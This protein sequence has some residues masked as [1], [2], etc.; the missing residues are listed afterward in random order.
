MCQ[1]FSTRQLIKLAFKWSK[2]VQYAYSIMNIVKPERADLHFVNYR[3]NSE[4][5]TQL[6]LYAKNEAYAE[7]FQDR[8]SLCIHYLK[9]TLQRN[10]TYKNI[11]IHTFLES[12]EQNIHFFQL[13]YF[14]LG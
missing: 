6:K 8:L 2:I 4:S 11:V 10:I 14:P 9:C 1:Q 5:V 13:K 3:D 7:Y 12:V